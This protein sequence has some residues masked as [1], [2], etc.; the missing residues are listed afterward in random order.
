L[1]ITK[2]K[3]QAP[4]TREKAAWDKLGVVEA[5]LD[6]NTDTRDNVIVYDD[7]KAGKIR[8][9]DGYSITSGQKKVNQRNIY[10]AFPIKEVWSDVMNSGLKTDLKAWM[11]KY[12]TPKE[13]QKHPFEEFTLEKGAFEH[14]KNT[15]KLLLEEMGLTMYTQTEPTGT[16]KCHI[17]WTVNKDL[18]TIYFN[19]SPTHNFKIDIKNTR[20]RNN[21]KEYNR[22]LLQTN[23]QGVNRIT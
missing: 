2:H 14:V 5:D 7:F 20:L 17:T 12:P 21:Q 4:T 19:L 10:S 9:I 8:S 1:Y 15:I 11:R 18:M 6:N 13:Q 23:P 16:L 3:I 22:Y